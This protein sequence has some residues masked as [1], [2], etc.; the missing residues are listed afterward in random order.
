MTIASSHKLHLLAANEALKLLNRETVGLLLELKSA[1]EQASGETGAYLEL[2]RIAQVFRSLGVSRN[3][4]IRVVATEASFHLEKLF[5]WEEMP[6]I[7]LD[8]GGSKDDPMWTAHNDAQLLKHFSD[9]AGSPPS[10]CA[11]SWLN[12]KYSERDTFK[13]VHWETVH[14][15]HKTLVRRRKKAEIMDMEMDEMIEEFM[16]SLPDLA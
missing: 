9:N 13:N 3:T 5:D 2:L 6:E 8:K 4:L 14:N 7:H 12:S 15:R 1:E 10:V 11:T 16:R